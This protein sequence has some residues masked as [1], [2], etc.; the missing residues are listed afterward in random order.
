MLSVLVVFGR[1]GDL[2]SIVPGAGEISGL[3]GLLSR[4]SSGWRC[5]D[6]N[7]AQM[8]MEVARLAD[9]QQTGSALRLGKSLAA[10][11]S[12]VN[13]QFGFTCYPQSSRKKAPLLWQH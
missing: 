6:E 4:F 9:G 8:M 12:D 13:S 7:V 11:T 5:D 1:L 10:A 2:I 3:F